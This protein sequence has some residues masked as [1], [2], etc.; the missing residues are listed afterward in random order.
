M[1]DPQLRVNP[2]ASIVKVTNSPYQFFHFASPCLL[3]LI[4]ILLLLNILLSLFYDLYLC[5]PPQVPNLSYFS[6][7]IDHFTGMIEDFTSLPCFHCWIQSFQSFEF[8]DQIRELLSPQ[9]ITSPGLLNCGSTMIQVLLHKILFLIFLRLM[10]YFQ[11][12][13]KLINK[14][15]SQFIVSQS[16]HSSHFPHISKV[17][18][19]F[20]EMKSLQEYY[21]P[22]LK[23]Q[24]SLFFANLGLLGRFWLDLC[25]CLSLVSFKHLLFLNLV[26]LL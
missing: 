3:Q 13:D 22:L 1:K 11:G 20:L 23:S 16:Q 19:H 17:L 25:G 14:T 24:Y 10:C 7:D 18:L 5:C 12:I 9:I 21:D 2:P 15:S 8:P 26:G 6:F 4:Q